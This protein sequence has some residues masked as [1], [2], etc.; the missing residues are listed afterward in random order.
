MAIRE[1]IT[2]PNPILR[3]KARKVKDFDK[4]LQVLI[5]DM[6]ETMRAEPGVGLA[7]PQVDVRLQVIVVEFGD[8]EDETVPP[9]LYT[10]VNPKI[11]RE[12]SETSLATEGCLSIPG[13]VGD[14]D[15]P[16]GVTVKGLNRHGQPLKIKATGWLARIFQH[17]IDHINGV[18]FVDRAENV[19]EIQEDDEQVPAAD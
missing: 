9:K 17:E 7:A 11:S 13:V 19:W 4:D 12:T 6:V 2:L 8:E 14:V 5:D 3:R 1:V 10:L 15:R 16:E 18:L